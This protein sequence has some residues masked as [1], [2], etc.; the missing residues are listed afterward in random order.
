MLPVLWQ[1]DGLKTMQ[2]NEAIYNAL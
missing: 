2:L 1:K